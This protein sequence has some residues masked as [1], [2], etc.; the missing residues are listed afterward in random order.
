MTL[1][2]TTT[3]LVQRPSAAEP[4]EPVAYTDGERVRGHISNPSGREAGGQE[5]V[6][7]RLDC[8]PVALSHADRVVDAEGAVYEVVWARQ[9]KGLGLDHTVAGL[10][11][12]EGTP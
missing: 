3:V 7:F 8:E 11:Q 6:E 12:V 10:R 9:R 5:D 1:L 2:T 4:F